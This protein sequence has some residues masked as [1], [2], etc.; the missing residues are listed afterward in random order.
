[1]RGETQ[2]SWSRFAALMFFIFMV[3]W[4]LF[5]PWALGIAT[6]IRRVFS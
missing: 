1:M 3:F 5:F 2:I 4:A 6:I